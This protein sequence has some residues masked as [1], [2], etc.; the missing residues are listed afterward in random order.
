[1]KL[2]TKLTYLFLVLTLSSTTVKGQEFF[3]DGSMKLSDISTDKKYGYEANHKTS[4]KVGKIENGQAYLKALRGPNGEQVQFMRLSSCCEF[5]SKSA[6]FGS[7]FLD[8]YEVYYEGLKEPILLYINGYDF[9]NPKTPLGFTFVTADKIE[10]PIIFPIDSIVK[11]SLCNSEEQYAVGKESLLKGNIGEKPEPETNPAFIGGI[12]EL[13][14]YFANN[15]LTDV[16]VKDAVFRVAIGFV[17]D[18]NGKSGN[19]KIITTI[20]KF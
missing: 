13:K 11:V 18:C 12:E 19:Y 4:I 17:V 9:E 15:P 14:K 1:M 6:A 10:K 3:E 8:K 20:R 5:K 2:T 16:R 7:G